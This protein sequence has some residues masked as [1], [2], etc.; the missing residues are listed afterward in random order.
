MQMREGIAAAVWVS[1]AS[2]ALFVVTA[3]LVLLYVQ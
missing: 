1:F 2:F 3:P